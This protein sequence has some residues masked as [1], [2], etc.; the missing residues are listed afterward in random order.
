M[1]DQ[2][3]TNYGQTWVW[4]WLETFLTKQPGFVKRH[5]HEEAFVLIAMVSPDTFWD[6]G[7]IKRLYPTWIKIMCLVHL[8][9]VEGFQKIPKVILNQRDPTLHLGH[10]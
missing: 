2:R 5:T 7:W 1:T 10:V 6:S 8:Q 3:H 9:H 4:D